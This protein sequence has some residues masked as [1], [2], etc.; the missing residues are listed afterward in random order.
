[1]F[2]FSN[3]K[4]FILFALALVTASVAGQCDDAELQTCA[5][6]YEGALQAEPTLL[7]DSARFCPVFQTFVDCIRTACGGVSLPQSAKTELEN[8]LQQNGVS[9]DINYGSAGAVPIT[10]TLSVPDQCD[11]AGIQTCFNAY[12][13][14]V[15]ADDTIFRDS[16]RYCPVIQTYVDCIRTACPGVSFPQSSKTELEDSLQQAGLSCDINYGSAGAVPITSTLSVPDQCD[17]AGIQ[18]CF[19]AYGAAVE[20]DDTIFRDSARYCP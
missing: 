4:I 5:S 3:M 18:T 12:G 10:S 15:E 14:A 7:T 20:A 2:V 13:A 17:E 8:S 11:E 19:N 9:C 6:D 1:V 16:A